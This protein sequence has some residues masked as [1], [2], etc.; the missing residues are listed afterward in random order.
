MSGDPP[1]R[2]GDGDWVSLVDGVRVSRT[3][4]TRHTPRLLAAWLDALT[5]EER[6]TVAARILR[7]ATEL[8]SEPDD[9]NEPAAAP[10]WEA[11]AERIDPR[12]P[13]GPD[14]P[15]LAAALD[16]AAAAGYDVVGRLPALAAAVPL[17]DRHPA[18]ELHWRLL[19]D[20]PAALPT[21]DAATGRS[22][23]GPGPGV[24]SP[25]GAPHIP[26]P[27]SPNE[28]NGEAS[29]RAPTTR[30]GDPP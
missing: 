6:H 19:D 1:A 13:L 12:L 15:P 3:W 25:A 22:A 2:P 8:E 29:T 16:R 7:I 9:G 24:H 20:C 27:I 28:A 5:P 17:P 30:G 14:W 11:V 10:A 18:R 26:G 23:P 21:L 4:M